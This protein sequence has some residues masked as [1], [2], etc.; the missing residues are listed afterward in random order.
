MLKT[1]VKCLTTAKLKENE[2]QH[3]NVMSDFQRNLQQI[4]TNLETHFDSLQDN[5]SNGSCFTS[6]RWTVNDGNI[7]LV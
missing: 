4:D 3:P 1:Q 6:A 5:F 2:T 7:T